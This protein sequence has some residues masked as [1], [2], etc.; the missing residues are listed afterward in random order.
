MLGESIDMNKILV[1][2][3]ETTDLR[4]SKGDIIEIGAVLLSADGTIEKAI[5][6]VVKP[7]KPVEM[8]QDCWTL[9]NTDLTVE[10]VLAGRS[11]I[12]VRDSLQVLLW[13]YP[14]TSYNRNFDIG[15]L[16]YNGFRAR[17]VIACPML[18]ASGIL[19][20]PGNY[21]NYKW[22]KLQ[23]AWDYFFPGGACKTHHRALDDARC[24]A[25]LIQKLREL[26][27]YEGLKE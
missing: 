13:H 25:Q 4:P 12:K 2:D 10:A 26:G 24:V 11:L 18:I 8:W 27:Y 17:W 23:E 15:Y 22:P 14:V 7:T 3:L 1:V 20:L 21:S 6:V 9:K 16:E 19:K 5:D